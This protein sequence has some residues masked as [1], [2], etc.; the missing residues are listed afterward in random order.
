MSNTHILKSVVVCSLIAGIV[1]AVQ[2]G[3]GTLRA[4]LSGGGATLMTIQSQPEAPEVALIQGP[5]HGA[6]PFAPL[7]ASAQ[8]AFQ[9]TLGL[10][11]ILLGFFLH[12]YMMARDE[13][14]VR[15]T[16]VTKQAASLVPEKE[17]QWFWVEIRV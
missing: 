10:L 1:L 13:R 16:D 12:A 6:A 4:N 3:L 7:Y 15:V 2:G 11:F 8:A 5:L 17:P 9:L 14:R